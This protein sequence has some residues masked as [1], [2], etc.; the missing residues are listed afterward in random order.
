MG[1]KT[2]KEGE[3]KLQEWRQNFVT[4]SLGVTV[5]EVTAT[6]PLDPRSIY[7]AYETALY[8]IY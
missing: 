1:T 6:L 2:A 3:P 4:E 7:F 8:F 5:I